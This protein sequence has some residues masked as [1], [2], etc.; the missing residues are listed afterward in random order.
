[1]ADPLTFGRVF[2]FDSKSSGV[3]GIVKL[4]GIAFGD[5]VIETP[6]FLVF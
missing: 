2:V 6:M 1:M 5:L 3:V 4:L